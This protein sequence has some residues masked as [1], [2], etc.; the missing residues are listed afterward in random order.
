MKMHQPKLRKKNGP[1]TEICAPPAF[2]LTA[3]LLVI[4]SLMLLFLSRGNVLM[5]PFTLGPLFV[6]LGLALFCQSRACQIT[7]IIGSVLYVACFISLVFSLVVSRDA[8]AGL[9]LG[10]MGFGTLPVMIPIWLMTL[11][12]NAKQ[13]I[14]APS[15]NAKQPIGAPSINAKQPIVALSVLLVALVI[16]FIEPVRNGVVFV[17]MVILDR[18]GF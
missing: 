16:A 3:C 9:A 4:V 2:I 12:F 6:S 1:F 8:Q 18:F 5:L 13:P 14:G 15:I 10:L 7:L 17:I 11:V